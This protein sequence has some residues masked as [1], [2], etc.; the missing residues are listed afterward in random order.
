MSDSSPIEI[1]VYS[2]W[3]I[4]CKHAIIT[5]DLNVKIVMVIF[6]H[7]IEFLFGVVSCT[8]NL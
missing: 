2:G 4:K 3:D 8:E 1:A 5:V 6:L 7:M